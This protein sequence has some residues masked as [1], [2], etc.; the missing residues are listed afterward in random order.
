MEQMEK[1]K[2]KRLNGEPENNCECKKNIKDDNKLK[3]VIMDV[4][5]KKTTPLTSEKIEFVPK[6]NIPNRVKQ[7]EN[8]A[9]KSDAYFEDVKT[10]PTKDSVPKQNDKLPHLGDE[11]LKNKFCNEKFNLDP[12]TNN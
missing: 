6:E 2:L 1:E 4:M 3:T 5:V 9:K 12:D 10:I 11:V 7:D 8:D